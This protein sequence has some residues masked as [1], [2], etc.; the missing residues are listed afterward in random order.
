MRQNKNLRKDTCHT[1][2]AMVTKGPLMIMGGW[3]LREIPRPQ[4]IHLRKL[5]YML[6]SISLI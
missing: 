3:T 1:F 2:N 4:V 6:V 5:E